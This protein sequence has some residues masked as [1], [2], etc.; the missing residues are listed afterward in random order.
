M[1]IDVERQITADAACR[2]PLYVSA[3]IILLFILWFAGSADK[4]LNLD[5]TDFPAAAE[6]TAV[7]GVPVYYKGEE[8]PNSLG[9]YHPPLYIYLLAAWINVFG[10]GEAQVRLF[11]MLCALLQG[12]IVLAI[13]R[14]L[15]GSAFRWGPIFW[16]I[17]L[18]N[19]YTLQTAAITDIDSTIYGP[20]LCLV[21]LATLRISWRDGE[22]RTDAV[23]W[24]EFASIGVAIF[25]CLWAKL[26][27]VL[28][29]FPVVFLLLIARKGIRQAALVAAAIEGA[30]IVAFLASYYLYGALV[31]LDVGVTFRFTLMVFYARGS[32]GTPGL[33]ALLRDHWN[34]LRAMVPFTMSWTGLLPWAAACLAL[35]VAFRAAIRQRDRRLLHYGLVLGLALLTTLCYCAQTMTFGSAPFKYTFVFWGLVL[36]APLFLLARWTSPDPWQGSSRTVTAAL[37][38]VYIAAEVWANLRVG[39]S[40]ML[41]GFAGPYSL[42]AYIPAL[43]FVAALAA[44]RYGRAGLA[45]PMAVLAVYCGLQF[46]VAVYQEQAPY[47]TTYDYGQMGFLDTVAFLKSNTRSNDVIAAMKDMGFRCRLRCFETYS[48]LTSGAGDPSVSR[49]M[50]AAASGRF[51][52]IVFTEGRGQDQLVRNPALRQWFL[53]RSTLVRSF[54]HYRIYQMDTRQHAAAR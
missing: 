25:L 17:F 53:K 47:S 33:A 44:T 19:P 13:I 2:I 29:V 14:T 23:S 26:T 24:L 1:G 27:T 30:S 28:L 31:G 54:G 20:L 52:Y 50:D 3:A 9:I 42:V 5:N 32:S 4:P 40:L 16:A 18:L 51:A 36:T 38:C 39:D 21:L 37:L 46:G 45:A 22:W 41:N 43:L 35:W 48:A 7:T 34:N 49:F 8:E 10:F 15:F 6:R 11:G 12:A